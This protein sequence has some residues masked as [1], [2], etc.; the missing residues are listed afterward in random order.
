MVRSGK[1]ER[2]STMRHAGL[3]GIVTALSAL[4][5]ATPSFA[6]PEQLKGQNFIDVMSGNTLSGTTPSGAAFNM[7]F[8]DGG[9]VT[10]DD[11][12]GEHDNGRW[13]IDPD[14]DVCITWRKHDPGHQSCYLVTVDGDQLSWKGKGGSGEGLLRGGVGTSFLKHP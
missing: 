9:D 14:G 6:A 11:S 12:S 1:I 2:S 3:L 4:G 13:L 5:L 7:Y 8:V 10:Y